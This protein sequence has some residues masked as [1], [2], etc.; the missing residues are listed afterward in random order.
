MFQFCPTL[1]SLL[2]SPPFLFSLYS[3]P[4]VGGE[5]KGKRVGGLGR[6]CGK[7]KELRYTEFVREWVGKREM[8]AE[9]TVPCNEK[10]TQPRGKFAKRFRDLFIS[11]Y[12]SLSLKYS[13]YVNEKKRKEETFWDHMITYKCWVFSFH[14]V[15]LCQFTLYRRVKYVLTILERTHSV[16][17]DYFYLTWFPN[18]KVVM[19]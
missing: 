17:A 5:R 13:S 12:F 18:S 2:P 10:S 4:K 3:S 7:Q 11:I 1:F 14:F 19:Y 16:S 15:S 6:K 8:Q 9:N